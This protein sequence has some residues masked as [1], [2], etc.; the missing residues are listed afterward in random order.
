MG[1]V[2]NTVLANEQ[3]ID[4]KGWRS[5]AEIEQ[6]KLS[7]WFFKI[8]SLASDLLESLGKMPEWPEKVKI[9]QK[10]WI[11]KSFGCEINFDLLS[12]YKNFEQKKIK[13][14][15]TRPDTIFGATFIAISP[16]HPLVDEILKNDK[17]IDKEVKQLQSQK[18][19]EETISK[20]EKVGIPTKLS[21]PHPLLKI[22]IFHYL[23]QTLF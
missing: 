1:P 14:F 15:T 23:S 20:N 22:K 6:K 8:T 18:L 16:F 9:M 19:N 2:E 4:G 5:G 17:N 13:I 11:G 21:I 3:V 12:G 7:Q 10:N